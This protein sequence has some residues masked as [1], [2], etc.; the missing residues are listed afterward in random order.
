MFV[1][2]ASTILQNLR[3]LLEGPQNGSVKSGIQ[4]AKSDHTQNG[5]RSSSEEERSDGEQVPGDL[6]HKPLDQATYQA[7]IAA[8]DGGGSVLSEMLSGSRSRYDEILVDPNTQTT[9]T[10][11]D[12]LTHTNTCESESTDNGTT[13]S[14]QGYLDVYYCVSHLAA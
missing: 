10:E 11:S 13:E 3:P 7:I 4:V 2:Q 9:E 12:S 6:Q 1:Q 5:I 14:K 8:D